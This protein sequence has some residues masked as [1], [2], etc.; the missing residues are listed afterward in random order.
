MQTKGFK[1]QS[2]KEN[3]VDL[4][5]METHNQTFTCTKEKTSKASPTPPLKI[6]LFLCFHI[7]LTTPTQI[8]FQTLLTISEA[9]LNLN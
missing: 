6:M 2:E 3:E 7:S 4:Q 8:V 1:H 9:Q 5:L